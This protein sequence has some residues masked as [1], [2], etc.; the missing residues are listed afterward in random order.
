MKSK[1]FTKPKTKYFFV[2]RKQTHMNEISVQY[3]TN[4]KFKL[5]KVWEA[6]NILSMIALQKS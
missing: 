4:P 3:V 6:A 2:H 5:C 1:L